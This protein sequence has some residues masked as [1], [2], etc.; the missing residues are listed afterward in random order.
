MGIIRSRSVT[1]NLSLLLA[2]GEP[3]AKGKVR[4]ELPRER[5]VDSL[6]E[7]ALDGGC[8]YNWKHSSKGKPGRLDNIDLRQWSQTHG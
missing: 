1:F 5:G 7:L 8:A 3:T 2:P 6:V 4:G